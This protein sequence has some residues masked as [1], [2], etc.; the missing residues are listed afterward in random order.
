[1]DGSSVASQELGRGA[2]IA[3][4][5]GTNITDTEL[6]LERLS[7]ATLM[8]IRLCFSQGAL[9]CQCLLAV[10]TS[11]EACGVRRLCCFLDTQ[12]HLAMFAHLHSLVYLSSVDK[13]AMESHS[14][15]GTEGKRGRQNST[16]C[17]KLSEPSFQVVKLCDVVLS[18]V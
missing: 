5:N 8:M 15:T 18:N 11:R 3:T 12:R 9:A 17:I 16:V 14:N 10:A 7:R 4:T 1:M 2:T 13:K 6:Q